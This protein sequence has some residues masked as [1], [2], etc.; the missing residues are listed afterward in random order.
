MA[1][2]LVKRNAD[3]RTTLLALLLFSCVGALI[4]YRTLI[5]LNIPGKPHAPA[6]GLVDFRDA[7]YYPVV[8]FLDGKNPYDPVELARNY[9]VGNVFPLYLPATLVLHLPFGLLPYETAEVAYI[10]AT[11]ALMPLIALLTLRLCGLRTSVTVV[12]GVATLMLLS[13]PGYWN[14]FLGQCTATVAL[15]TYAALHFARHRPMLA[16]LG[17]AVSSIKPTFGIPLAVLMLAKGNIRPVV[18]GLGLSVVFSAGTAAVIASNSGGIG[19]FAASL[20]SSHS[21]FRA[22]PAIEAATS[23]YRVDVVALLSRVLGEA[24]PAAAEV[25]L[26]IGLLA[27]AALAIRRLS[28]SDASLTNG[29]A[30]PLSA[31]LICVAV[32]V[33]TYHQTYDL[34]LLAMPLAAVATG[35][36]APA[37]SAGPWARGLLLAALAL[38]ASNYLVSGTAIGRLGITGGWRTAVVSL[39]GAALLLAFLIYVVSALRFSRRQK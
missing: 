23:I 32:L 35:R 2:A 34:L 26:L 7:I 3:R 25:G 10:V 17:V 14:L 37:Q 19:S 31:G 15:G 9:P 4:S 27:V 28:R 33:C 22:D 16:G 30:G 13:R 6:W 11:V 29:A 1:G 12:F 5:G 24:L 39:N 36:W 18:I 8:A 20:F 38:L 21:S